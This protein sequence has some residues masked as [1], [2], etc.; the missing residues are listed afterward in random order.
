[1]PR[2]SLVPWCIVFSPDH[3]SAYPCSPIEIARALAQAGF[4]DRAL[5]LLC[6]RL[7]RSPADL[8]A[9]RALAEIDLATA[10]PQEAA[11]ALAGAGAGLATSAPAQLLLGDARAAVGDTTAARAAYRRA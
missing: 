4:P 11:A 9:R 1:M 7:A 10:R 2:R 6:A 3:L 5:P 8:D